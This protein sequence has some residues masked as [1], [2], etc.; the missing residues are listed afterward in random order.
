MLH[1]PAKV[2]TQGMPPLDVVLEASRV[3]FRVEHKQNY[4]DRQTDSF[5]LGY[6]PLVSFVD[7]TLGSTAVDVSVG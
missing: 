6:S 3:F 7:A 2:T 1:E 4:A 5:S